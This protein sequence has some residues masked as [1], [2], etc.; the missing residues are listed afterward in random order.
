MFVKINYLRNSIFKDVTLIKWRRVSIFQHFSKCCDKF[1]NIELCICRTESSGIKNPGR[2]MTRLVATPVFDFTTISIFID[3]KCL[4]LLK[5]GYIKSFLT[6]ELV[7][8]CNDRY[9]AT[10]FQFPTYLQGKIQ[11]TEKLPRTTILFPWFIYYIT[12]VVISNP[13]TTNIQENVTFTLH[14]MQN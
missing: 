4:V 1:I 2:D 8:I 14:L 12:T 7:N 11:S 10:K 6:Y 13:R 3:S 9:Y 5:R